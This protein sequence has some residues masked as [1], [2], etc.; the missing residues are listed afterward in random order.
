M[1]SGEDCGEFGRDCGGLIDHVLQD[2]LQLGEDAEGTDDAGQGSGISGV[3]C[4]GC[5]ECG[6]RDADAFGSFADSGVGR[7]VGGAAVAI[8]ESESGV[9]G[10]ADR[11][12]AGI[13]GVDNASRL[14]DV[15][16]N[17]RDDKVQHMDAILPIAGLAGADQILAEASEHPVRKLTDEASAFY[18]EWL[19]AVT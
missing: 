14:Q 8:I 19:T 6:G 18:R 11:R 3:E 12:Q 7:I 13:V 5:L 16:R 17:G 15:K 4:S 10:T 9:V 2:R 1:A